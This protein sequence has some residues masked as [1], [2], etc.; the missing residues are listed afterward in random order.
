MVKYADQGRQATSQ[1]IEGLILFGQESNSAKLMGKNTVKMVLYHISV[2][3]QDLKDELFD[4]G[5]DFIWKNTHCSA[6]RLNLFHITNDAATKADPEI[7]K[8]LKQ[9]KFKWK[10]VQNDS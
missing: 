4:L 10:T 6:I 9:R 8:I 3:N 5:L 2:V 1:N 7:K